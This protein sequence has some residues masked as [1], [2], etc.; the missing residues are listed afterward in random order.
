VEKKKRM[1]R[2]E[3]KWL[4]KGKE[5]NRKRLKQEYRKRKRIS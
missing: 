4:E 5:G 3:N 2:A 1:K